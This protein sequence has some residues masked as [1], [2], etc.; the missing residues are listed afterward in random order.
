MQKKKN[1]PVSTWLAMLAWTLSWSVVLQFIIIP[2][3]RCLA[4]QLFYAA[5]WPLVTI[6]NLMLVIDHHPWALLG[7]GLEVLL[8]LVITYWMVTVWFN[9]LLSISQ[10]EQIKFKTGKI[11]RP[12]SWSGISVMLLIALVG[13][14]WVNLLYRTPLW[15]Q[16]QLPIFLLDFLPRHT[17]ILAT[18]TILYLLAVCL[19]YRWVMVLPQ[20]MLN[21]L[22]VRQALQKSWQETKGWAGLQLW[23]SI[24]LAISWPTL[25][26]WLIYGLVWVSPIA[27]LPRS[28][29]GLVIGGLQII[30]ELALAI[31]VIR[32][33]LVLVGSRNLKDG[34]QEPLDW[35]WGCL[36]LLVLGLLLG[37]AIYQGQVMNQMA[38]KKP[39]VISHR[40]VNGHNG[41]QN[42]IPALLKTIRT[43]HPNYVEID[44]HETK[45][46]QFVVM[47]DEN[48]RKLAGIN[49]RPRQL[50]LRQL[51][52]I[53][54]RENGYR[55]K[56]VNLDQY[57]KVA[58]QHH[59][60][61]IVELKTSRY[62]SPLMVNH[63]VRRYANTLIT[64]HDLVHSLDYQAL[65]QMHHAAPRLSIVD[66]QG[67]NLMNPR[68][69]FQAYTMEYG[70]LN[71]R[72]MQQAHAQHQRIF[73]WTVDSP[74]MMR[75][76]ILMGADGIVTDRPS[77]L[78]R[79]WHQIHKLDHNRLILW[80]YLSSF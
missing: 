6:A 50:T 68:T 77:E 62:D 80:T 22:A 21:H 33:T 11:W 39:L 16:I 25:I 10:G 71:N 43:S 36:F 20:I 41:V 24:C 55:A 79:V 2:V 4:S 72:F 70:S 66:I 9:G 8:A 58:Q 60:K 44:V 51:E 48:L 46:G 40:G 78:R 49:R 18:A 26:L 54:V 53:T 29:M 13:L 63:F 7:L 45:D 28:M 12:D 52:K 14:P 59:Q 75:R 15:S 27:Q 67:Y 35:R 32:L 56:L 30:S 61:L 23:R 64:H 1:Q 73:A 38:V 5:N 3:G 57:L 37:K 34:N 65:I 76:M 19:M 74:M 69:S 47:H 42:T 17:W 31:I